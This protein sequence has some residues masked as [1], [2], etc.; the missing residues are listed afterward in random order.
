MSIYNL[1]LKTMNQLK[2]LI[3]LFMFSG[4][5][6][7]AITCKT[8][9]NNDLGNQMGPIHHDQYGIYDAPRVRTFPSSPQ[10]VQA[11]I[12]DMDLEQIR[13]HAWDIWESMNTDTAQGANYPIWETWYTGH[14]LFEMGPPAKTE[15]H[16]IRDFEIAAQFV[17]MS[18]DH[19]DEIPI[20]PA[21]RPTSFNRFSR[22]TAHAIWDKEINMANT[23][24][25]IN[26]QMDVLE[27]PIKD[28]EVLASVDTVD[29]DGFVL[30]PLFQ[31][32]SGTEPTALPYWA[33]VTA[34]A[35]F[36]QARPA[37]HTWTQCVIIDP[38]DSLEV[39]S[40]HKMNCNGNI[41]E[42]EVID[43][44][45]IYNIQFDEETAEN[46]SKFAQN[47]GGDDLGFG[48]K[49]DSVS[50]KK[51]IK[52]GNYALLMAMHV[53]GKEIRNWT[54]QTYWWSP[55]DDHPPYGHD[56]PESIKAPW[57]NYL[58]RTAYYMV[59]PPRHPQ[60]MPHIGYNPYLEGNLKFE[61][62]PENSDSCVIIRGVFSNCMTCHIKAVYPFPKKNFYRMAGYIDKG[63]PFHFKDV[64]KTDFLWSLSI[65]AQKDSSYHN[66][67]N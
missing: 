10:V 41:D 45:R 51:M 37:P 66:N 14:E 29:K 57:S 32:I 60:G 50:I 56:R 36:D 42:W 38:T 59:N 16:G 12:D 53:T 22:T 35:T 26:K 19:K 48:N 61:F 33:G 8:T 30:K 25:S 3:G 44:D 40:K 9:Q 43:I 5:V 49:H 24:D 58:M 65:R 15:R 47:E 52:A 1:N 21:E 63:D 13:Q 17:H 6:L 11:W 46:F 64:V 39:G 7:L 62:T 2:V 23:L 27:T 34:N 55:F 4:I 54:W 20:D 18:D 28:R 67:G 31:F